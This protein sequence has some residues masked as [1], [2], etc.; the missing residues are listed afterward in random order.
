M[1]KLRFDHRDRFA[2]RFGKQ[3]EIKASAVGR[4]RIPAMKYCILYTIDRRLVNADVGLNPPP[5]FPR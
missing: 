3:A 5:A 2:L 1:E 4:G